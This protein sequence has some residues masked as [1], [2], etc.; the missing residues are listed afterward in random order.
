MA[1]KASRVD[2]FAVEKYCCS[3]HIVGWMGTQ[4]GGMAVVTSEAVTQSES[5]V[6]RW[7]CPTQPQIPERLRTPSSLLCRQTAG[8]TFHLVSFL[9]NSFIL[10]SARCPML[11]QDQH[12]HAI[13]RARAQEY[14]HECKR[15]LR[16]RLL[17]HKVFSKAVI[18]PIGLSL[19]A[20]EWDQSNYNLQRLMVKG[21]RQEKK[22][23]SGIKQ[24]V[25]SCGCAVE[26][27]C[28][29]EG[30]VSCSVPSWIDNT[31]RA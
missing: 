28:E 12:I 26:N 29:P 25:P 23:V 4:R 20:F 18:Y 16:F 9:E 2:L 13:R 10:F 3:W 19:N 17:I 8:S 6:P 24:T 21:K 27:P 30:R 5:H 7:P 22:T 11:A 15:R 31:S 14:V 1:C